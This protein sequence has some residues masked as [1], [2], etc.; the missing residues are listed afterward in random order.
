MSGTS[1]VL[2]LVLEKLRR[3][4]GRSLL[5]LGVKELIARDV[6]RIETEERKGKR[7]A[8]GPKL[9]LVDGP[10]SSPPSRALQLLHRQI[11]R[12]PSEVR[13]GR[14]VRELTDVAKHLARGSAR[15]EVLAAALTDLVGMGLVREEERRVLRVFRRRVMVRTPGGESLLEADE[16]RRASDRSAGTTDAAFF[17][18]LVDPGDQHRPGDHD[19]R[20]DAATTGGADGAFDGRF[21]GSLD[22]GF[23]GAFDASFD[24]AFDASFDSAFD[25]G[26]SDGGGGGGDGGGGGGD[27]GGGGG[28]D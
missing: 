5:K 14:V 22:G 16:R 1:P 8:K 7:R 10:T 3:T 20:T 18:I 26:F 2:L 12:M 25:A 13:D 21:E 6:F 23:D 4:D 28:G 9:L 19:E 27:G 15:G 24:S 11:D 17:P